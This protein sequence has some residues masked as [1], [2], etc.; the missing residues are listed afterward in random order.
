M[1]VVIFPEHLRYAGSGASL[2]PHNV[3]KLVGLLL[4]DG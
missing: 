1:F 4:F 2:I 3:I